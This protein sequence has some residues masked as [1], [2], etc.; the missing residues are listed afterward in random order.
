MV[1]P[2][3]NGLSLCAGGGGLDMGIML[4]EPDFHTRCF[5]E[6]EEHP[7]EVLIAGM[8][9]GYF[10]PAPIWDNVKTFDAKPFAGAFD[11]VIAG[12]P[13]QP[14]SAAGQRKGED[15]PRHLWPDIDR[16]IR[17]LGPS[18]R[19]LIFENVA[20]HLT[21]GLDTVLHAIRGLGFTAA[22]GVFSAEEVSASHERQRIFIV[23]Y[24][25]GPDGRGELEA[26]GTRCRRTGSAGDGPELADAN[27]GDASPEWEQRG[28]EQRFQPEGRGSSLKDLAN[29]GVGRCGGPGERQDQQPRR[30]EAERTGDH[31]GNS[32][33]LGCGEGQ[34][35]PELRSGW[36]T[37][38]GA[39]CELD[40]P[41]RDGRR[42]RRN[43]NHS[44]HVGQQPDP[45]GGELA[46][47]DDTRPQGQLS[48]EHHPQGRQ[49]PDGYAGL[50]S[51]AGISPPGPSDGAAWASV[52]RM[53]PDLAPSTAFGDIA[54]Q[55][56]ELAAL[57]EAGE[58]AETKAES[59]LCRMV[60]GLASRTRA[61][62][63]LG[64]GVH[65]L[66][67]GYAFRTLS[68]AHGLGWVDLEGAG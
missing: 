54:R 51:R 34:P 32:E 36:D 68:A 30:A 37:L 35:E 9:A 12:Y 13:C 20:G 11:T 42:T 26:R 29:T 3:R 49:V 60:D 64:N 44:E 41:E 47:S 10:A 25:E 56:G 1:L 23:A 45:K 63:L 2:P 33:G 43:G 4:A 59:A 24:R 15:D 48:N 28:R 14:F 22:V 65:P 21:L 52:L 7:R 67:A 53:A 31:V 19:W 5:V 57:V 58:L 62:R 40:Y 38:A 17:E 16:I 66:A 27:G 8:R 50:R 61:L 6:W 18:V 55:A 46:D 39:S